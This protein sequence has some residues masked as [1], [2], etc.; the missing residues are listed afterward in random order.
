MQEKDADAPAPARKRGG[1]KT[2]GDAGRAKVS[3]AKQGHFLTAREREALRQGAAPATRSEYEGRRADRE[4][5]DQASA[6][7]RAKRKALTFAQAALEDLAFLASVM[8][9][10]WL[11]E[12]ATHLEPPPGVPL[13]VAQGFQMEGVLPRLLESLAE[14]VG[15]ERAPEVEAMVDPHNA[16]LWPTGYTQGGS[17]RLQRSGAT[18]AALWLAGLERGLNASERGRQVHTLLHAV[19][20]PPPPPAGEADV[21]RKAARRK[22]PRGRKPSAK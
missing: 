12:L 11:Y 7:A 19:R 20:A 16:S 18:L 1:A 21:P 2:G 22:L 17:V 9:P 8:D 3:R 14:K 5:K 13:E 10:D 15:A 4:R 6:H